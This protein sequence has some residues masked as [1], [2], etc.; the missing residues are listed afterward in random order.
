MTLPQDDDRLPLELQ[1]REEAL[2]VTDR[3]VVKD[4]VRDRAHDEAGK[5]YLRV[6]QRTFN[7]LPNN[8][9]GMG[10]R[11]NKAAEKAM[12]AYSKTFHDAYD[13]AC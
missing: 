9:A 12:R 3:S 5:E 4:T 10:D 8:D 7:N 13:N 2:S 6:F 11:V 1:A